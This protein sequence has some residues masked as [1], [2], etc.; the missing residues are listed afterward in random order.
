MTNEN[1]RNMN[2]IL[3]GHVE[4]SLPLDFI[5]VWAEPKALEICRKNRDRTSQGCNISFTLV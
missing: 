3:A 2:E 1:A 4:N 5:A